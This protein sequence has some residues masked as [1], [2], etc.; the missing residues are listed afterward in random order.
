MYLLDT[1]ILL[2]VLLEQDRAEEVEKFMNNTNEGLLHLS[3]LTL[4]SIGIK[5]NLKKKRMYF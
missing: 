1:N 5:L 3:E 2:E 4:Y